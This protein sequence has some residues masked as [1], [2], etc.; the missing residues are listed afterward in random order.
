MTM[1]SEDANEVARRGAEDFARRLVQHWHEILGAELL[2]AYLIGSLAH[3]GFNR[4]YSDVDLALVT[5]VGLSREAL[6]S[7]KSEAVALSG[8]WGS[9]VSIFWADR[10][11]RAGRFPPLDRVDYHDHGVAILE[12]ERIRPTRPSLPEIRDYLRDTPLEQWGK[13]SRHYCELPE[14]GAND[15]KPYLRCLLYPARLLY[16]WT[17]GAMASNDDA[18]QFLRR[19]PVPDL[20]L[21]LIERALECRR[22]N[23]DLD[24][25]FPQ[26]SRLD[27]QYA[28]CADVISRS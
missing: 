14:L 18:V 24:A 22:E 16:S 3:A 4:R 7:L 17:T 19:H 1:T 28:V 6:D 21:D 2:G 25:L 8:D 26:R 11:F 15:H 10:H 20:D 12:R 5:D 23:R 9:K 27:H 13:Q